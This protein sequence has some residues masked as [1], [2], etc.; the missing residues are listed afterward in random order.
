[1]RALTLTGCTSDDRPPD[2]NDDSSSTDPGLHVFLK[3]LGECAG[4]DASWEVR[5]AA[6]MSK[7]P[8]VS[9]P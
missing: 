3:Q 9:V 1:M 6:G 4:G 8:S 7:T 5:Y 2:Y